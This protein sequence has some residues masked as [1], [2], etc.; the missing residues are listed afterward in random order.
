MRKRRWV[1][2]LLL[3]AG[4]IYRRKYMPHT[5]LDMNEKN[6]THNSVV[7]TLLKGSTTGTNQETD[8]TIDI[9]QTPSQGGENY[10]GGGEYADYAAS[11]VSA[12]LTA[13]KRAILVFERT[14]DPT[15]TA[16]HDDV[17]THHTRIPKDTIIFFVNIDNE[18]SLAQKFQVENANTIIYL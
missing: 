16:L 15:A 13:N 5:F 14:G 3:I 6:D 12:T 4:G 7:D 8:N 11:A 1:I 9:T 17:I 18:I 2:I 10:A